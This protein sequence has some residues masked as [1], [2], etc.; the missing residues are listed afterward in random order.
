MRRARGRGRD[1]AGRPGPGS[2]G[3]AGAT[4]TVRAA[5]RFFLPLIFMT[6]LNAISKSVIHAFLAR[7]PHATTSLAGFNVAF[8]AY[9]AGSS[10]T[11]VSYLVTLSWLRDRRS[12]L[13]LLRFFCLITAGPVALALAVAFTAAGD[14][15]YGGLFGASPAVVR[16]AKLATFVF[17]LSA[18]FLIARAFT[19]G[20]L[21]IN[22]RTM[23]I[24]WSTL[25]R[26]ASL[27]GSLVLLPRFLSGAAA[28]AAALVTCMAVEAIVSGLLAARYF[29]A[30]PAAA[31]PPPRIRELWRFAWPLMLNSSAEMGTVFVISIFLGRLLDP[32]LALAAFG[33]VHGLTSL[34]MS[35]MRNLLHTAQTLA[36]TAADRAALRRFSVQVVV[37]FALIAI[38]LFDTPVSRVVLGRL[39]GLPLAL[40]AAC[41]PAMRLAFVMAAAWGF[42]A[43]LRGFL[44]GARRTG[45]LALTG[46][47]RLVV[48]AGV[49]ALAFAA[50]DL[51]GALLGLAAWFAGY[52]AE[53][54]YLALRLR[55]RP[56]VAGAR[57]G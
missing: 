20:V 51:D 19:F 15:L 31:G 40:E 39:M 45:S 52:G 47:G 46:A 23:L 41:A 18:P 44:A 27:G 38:G 54:V 6:E 42:S 56:T 49:G 14:W 9:Y 3:A 22:R 34:M 26:L 28:G 17:T 29:R 12:I 8:T 57:I 30:L 10:A 33:V 11:E 36:R 50:R 37:V 53:A 55:A 4:V 16:E 32:D 7:L 2:S 1:R 5:W 13:P 24:S 35:P 43:L 25:A 48:A 21:M